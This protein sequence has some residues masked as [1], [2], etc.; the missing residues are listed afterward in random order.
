MIGALRARGLWIT[1]VLAAG[2]AAHIAG[3]W[4]GSEAEFDRNGI[5][6]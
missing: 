5:G 4:S 2:P 1:M 6:P 3:P